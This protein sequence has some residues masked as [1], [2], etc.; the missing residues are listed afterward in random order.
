MPTTHITLANL[1]RALRAVAHVADDDTGNECRD[2]VQIDV[3]TG[4][5]TATAT[6]RWRSAHAR[7]TAESGPIGPYRVNIARHHAIKIVRELSEHLPALDINSETDTWP[8]SQTVFT[9]NSPEADRYVRIYAPRLGDLSPTFAIPAV[10]VSRPV[11]ALLADVFAKDYPA[12]VRPI[13]LNMRWLAELYEGVGDPDAGSFWRVTAADAP[14]PIKIEYGDWFVALI[15][16]G[17]V[18]ASTEPVP[19]GPPAA[20]HV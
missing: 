10:H 11:T 1:V 8:N 6:N 17:R 4:H 3:H 7:V 18:P 5:L 14:H 12:P 9:L 15:M 13:A 19:F 2:T 16:P 20:T